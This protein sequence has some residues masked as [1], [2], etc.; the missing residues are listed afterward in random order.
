MKQER[1]VTAQ[2][3]GMALAAGLLTVGCVS[4]RYAEVQTDYAKER[5]Q[6]EQRLQEVIVA[7]ETKDFA[8]LDSY[9]LYGPKFT[10]F[11]G[12]TAERLDAAA[13]REGEHKGLGAA[14]GLKMRADALKI[15][16]FD[17]VGIATFIL[18]YSFESGG[19]TI[20][21]KERSTL[22]FVNDGGAWKIA[23]EHLSPI[24]E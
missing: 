22:V 18:D 6:I 15:D 7:A 4:P 24:K 21:R 14:N 10:K 13:G 19:Q 5:T 1:K 11:T 23:H 20:R 8:R 9:H 2:W 17:D 12:S 3:I 16:V